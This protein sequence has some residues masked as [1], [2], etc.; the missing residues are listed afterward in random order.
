MEKNFEINFSKNI[1]LLRKRRGRTQDD[2][3][4]TLGMKRSTLSGY[5]NNV[6]QPGISN[7]VAFS[8]Y[9]NVAVDTLLKIDLGK[10]SA[11]QLSEIER[12]YDVYVSGSRLR[13]LTTTIDSENEEN[14]ELI[15]EQAK[16]GYTRGFADP[17]YISSLPVFKLPFLSQQR[18]YR[19]FQI[20]GESMLPIPDG[21]WITGEF[22]Q[23]WNQIENNKAHIILTLDEGIVF[24]VIK[25]HIE[26]D[27]TLVLYSLNPEYEPYSLPITQVREIW[28]F[29]HFISP[30]LPEP[31]VPKS[32]L[33]DAIA[34]LKQDM[35]KIKSKLELE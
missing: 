26:T 14:I 33:I 15:N 20:T 19:T 28:R 2:V 7:L 9:F 5:E 12:G 35:T 18:K 8:E 4:H 1:K 34:E 30:E 3:A 27:K 17:E 16:A 10:L 21:A 22:L 23:D 24:K 29:I 11:S 6:A 13:I 25:S 31:I 32:N